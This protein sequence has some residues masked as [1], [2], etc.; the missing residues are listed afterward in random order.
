MEKQ[1]KKII[2]RMGREKLNSL[3][4]D[5]VRLYFKHRVEKLLGTKRVLVKDELGYL[6]GETGP[7]SLRFDPRYLNL[8]LQDSV[9]AYAPFQTIPEIQKIGVVKQK[10]ESYII[11]NRNSTKTQ[12]I[13]K[14]LLGKHV[15]KTEIVSAHPLI[16]HGKIKK[17]PV[18]CL[19]KNGEWII[20]NPELF[21][22]LKQ[23]Q[24]QKR[25]PIVIGKKISGILFPV[26]KTLSVLGLNIYKIYLPE[27]TKKIIESVLSTEEIM[28]D[29]KYNNQFIFGNNN[30]QDPIVNFFNGTVNNYISNYYRNFLATK[31]K[32]TDNFVDTVS[33]FRKNRATKGLIENHEATQKIIRGLRE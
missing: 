7:G 6:L 12:N 2:Q 13:L 17:I 22:F 19:I 18:S 30:D 23:S 14:D 20:P 27:E 29:M 9:F 28:K 33:Q 3:K 8:L 15:R 31:I 16:I 10:I 21:S 4:P 11:A 32:I 25:F 1:L 24:D 5:E 26:F